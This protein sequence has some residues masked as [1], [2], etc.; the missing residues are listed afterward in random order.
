MKMTVGSKIGTGIAVA[1][2]MLVLIGGAS[3]QTTSRSIENSRQVQHTLEVIELLESLRG[4]LHGVETLQRGY[5]LTGSARYLDSYDPTLL[6]ID[7]DLNGLR[8][9]TAD[10]PNQQRRLVT[11]EPVIKERLAR[12]AEASAARKDKGL[13]A[14]AQLVATGTGKN[15]MDQIET[16]LKDM[17]AEESSL[18]AKRSSQASSSATLAIAAITSGVSIAFIVLGLGGAAL[19]RNIARPLRQVATTAERMAA[20]E[21]PETLAADPREDE[22]GTLLRA[23]SRMAA[24]QHDMAGVARRIAGGDLRMDVTPLSDNDV[25]GSAFATMMRDLRRI[26]ADMTEAVTVLESAAAEI[27]ASSTQTAAS[28]TETATSVS[29]TSATVEE[30]RQTAELSCQKARHVADNAQ[31]AA[32]NAES[33]RKAVEDTREEMKRIRQQMESIA[34]G[35]VRLSDQSKAI[36]EIIA[37]VED[38]A[39]QSNLLAV[40]AAI[41]AAKAGEQGKGFAVVAQEVKN[42]AEQSRQATTRVRNILND[43]QK[44]ASAAAMVT[45]QGR[46]AVDAGVAQ[47][48][49][50]GESILAL[51]HSVVEASGSAVQIAASSQQQLTGVDQ[52]ASAVNQIK[53]AT[54]D[55]AAAMKQI[56][57]AARNLNSLGEKLKQTVTRFQAQETRIR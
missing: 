53:Q 50:A 26:S 30:V 14:A 29:E 27:L 13:E 45:E 6:E 23:F 32:Q 1:L 24:F 16:I 22:V 15:L 4:R 11:L 20:G 28:A 2:G 8:A 9:L 21:L 56:E 54:A 37:S 10:N 52:V 34:E 5:I 51:A 3:Y 42:L 40:N 7:K 49:Q 36:A 35:M 18:L 41:E 48:V 44:A 46:N 19:T 57:N 43:I 33:G 38:L 25:L 39:Q 55:N 12:L 47:A 17:H 31:R